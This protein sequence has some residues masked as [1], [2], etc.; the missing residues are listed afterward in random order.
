MA[1]VT[2]RV[3]R[4]FDVKVDADYGDTPQDLEKKA[5]AV[6]KGKPDA[7]TTVVLPKEED[8]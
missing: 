3:I 5:L 8:K 4:T 2:V 1:K 6:A 7:E